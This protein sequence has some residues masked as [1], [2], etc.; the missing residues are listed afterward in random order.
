MWCRTDFSRPESSR[1]SPDPGI[2]ACGSTAS[3]LRRRAKQRAQPQSLKE[4]QQRM[5]ELLPVARA[6]M[7]SLYEQI[8]GS[9][10][11]VILSDTQG[12]VLSTIT[13]PSLQREFRQAGLSL[14]ALWD[15]RHEGTNGIGTCLAE[16]CR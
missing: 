7:E 10:F 11:A 12:A 1:W 9:G 16:G 8:A 3:S 5:G 13:D 15:E 6:E 2:A 14:G 4:L